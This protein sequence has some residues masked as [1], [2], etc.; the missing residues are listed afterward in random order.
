MNRQLSMQVAPGAFLIENYLT[1]DEQKFFILR[2]KELGSEP[3]GFYTPAVRTG[4]YMS[5]R[6]MCLGL[7]WNAQTYKYEKVRSDFDGLPVQPIPEDFKETARRIAAHAGMAIEPDIC[8]VNFYTGTGKLGL[9]QDK[10]E[11]PE[12]L[13]KGIPVVS[14]SL[15]DS[16]SFLFGGTTRK[17][18]VRTILLKSGDA[19]LFGGPSRMRFHGVSSIIEGSAPTELEVSGRY[20]LTFRQY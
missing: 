11:R 12:T 7:H 2:C 13:K 6:M 9:H 19:F 3:A 5:I 14:I 16:G 18:P 10:D 1:T 4:A 15:G 8:L 20:N 17:D